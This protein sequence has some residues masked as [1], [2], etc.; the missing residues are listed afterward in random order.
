VLPSCN[1]EDQHFTRGQ[2]AVKIRV[3]DLP[4]DGLS[5]GTHGVAAIYSG[6]GGFAALRRIVIRSYNWFN[7]LYPF[8]A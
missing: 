6:S 3:L 4:P 7:W 1:G 5:I 2:F 8:N